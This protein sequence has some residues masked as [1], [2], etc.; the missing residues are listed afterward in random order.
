MEWRYSNLFTWF[1][2]L[3]LATVF[4][5]LKHRKSKSGAK[6]R[7]PGP[8]PWLIFGNI[9]NL[10]TTPHQNLYKYRFK[11]GPILWLRLG[12]INTLVIQS[13]K[14]A[15]EL[16]KNHD[17]S[18]C[19]R[20]VP[21]CYTAHNY[22][23][24]S[25]S[26]GQY[27]SRW[28]FHRRLVTV[29]LMTNKR[30]NDTTSIRQKCV[31]NM[32]Q[33][34]EEDISSAQARGES[35]EVE[36]ARYVF[37]MSF[38]L[39]G[40]LVLS[41]DL[42]NSQSKEG[43]EF[44]DALNKVAR[45]GAKPN[46]ADLF[47]FFKG[48]DPQRIKSNM[49]KE[50]GQTLKIVEGFVRKRIEER[51]LVKERENKDFLDV[52]LEYEGVGKE[53]PDKISIQNIFIMILEMFFGGTET[54]SSTVEWAMAELFRS[55]ES[56]RRVKE[57]LNRVVGP[58]RKVE[59]SDI[60]GLPYLQAVIKETMRLHPIFPL[61]IPRN[62]LYDTN[63]M[64]YLIPKDT[65]VFVNVW[66]IARD[67]DVWEDP[68]SFK[69]ERF[70]DSNIDYRGQNF[71]LLPFGAGRRICPGIPMAHRVLHHVVASL[72]H[73]FDWEVGSGSTPRTIDMKEGMGITVRKLIPLRATPKKINR[74]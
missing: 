71:E 7:P 36:V 27:G 5:L 66:A 21:E 6:L 61:L 67:P 9:F 13:A 20:K 63:F 11:Y 62:T 64:G 52:L 50:L 47:P 33:F 22:N 3:F 73:C 49:E 48:S 74:E 54:T 42:L 46:V 58:K 4:L 65:Q 38:N 31:N 39:I 51:K 29:E 41:W 45:M 53:E 24:S 10:G 68:L 69:P 17:F 55:P 2:F 25:V 60:H 26:L 1:S 37:I 14:A 12:S 19:D 57:E 44:F 35:M 72:L 70:I 15:E 40:N 23:Q 59:E 18:F 34:I 43:P 56:M 28:R 16:F 30:I 8:K 32:L